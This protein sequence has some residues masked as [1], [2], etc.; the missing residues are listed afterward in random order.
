M[1]EQNDIPSII[2]HFDA[3]RTEYRSLKDKIEKLESE[4][5]DLS[6]SLIPQM[7]QNQDVKTIKLDNVGRV[8]VNVRWTASM[9]DKAAGM[10]WLRSTGNDGII[11]ETV[12]AQTLASFAKELAVGGTPLPDN[13]FTVG[14]SNYT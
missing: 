11:I 9:P 8:T 6:Y 10:D 12:N 7:F 1:V 4:V 2:K 13:L 5:N 14:T 3:L